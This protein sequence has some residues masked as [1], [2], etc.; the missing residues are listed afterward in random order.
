MMKKGSKNVLRA[1]SFILA[2]VMIISLT[3]VGTAE[4]KTKAK[5]KKDI[6]VLY[7][8]GTGTTKATARR[9]GKKT[10]GKVLEIKAKE[11]YTE[12]DLDYGN[13]DSRVVKEHESAASPA[14]STVRPEIA[15]LK[16]IKKAV[17]KAD[18]VYIGYPIWWGEAPHIVYTLV[19]N[20]SLK[21]KTVVPFSTSISSG[22]GDSG[23]N[24]KTKAKISSKT[25][26]LKGRGFYGVPSQKTVNKWVNKLKY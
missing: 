14:Q 17:K 16:A 22:H 15:N 3:D 4:A 23:K 20:V 6:V 11:P 19:E 7:F 26:W 2:L 9:I 1:V 21:G 8:S 10:K 5:N 13:D 24:L 12:E 25:N 18:V